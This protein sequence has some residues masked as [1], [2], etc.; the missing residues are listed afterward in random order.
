[1]V[2]PALYRTSLQQDSWAW[3]PYLELTSLAIGPFGTGVFLSCK[4][5]RLRNSL[6]AAKS[7]G[8]RQRT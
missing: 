1:M 3:S 6:A 2:V 7:R 5:W 4:V 8:Q